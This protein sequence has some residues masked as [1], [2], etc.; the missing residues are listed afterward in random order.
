MAAALG[1]GAP[2]IPLTLRVVVE[3][4][5]T[6]PFVVRLRTSR[7]GSPPGTRDALLD[8]AADDNGLAFNTSDARLTVFGARADE[9]DNDVVLLVPRRGTLRRLIRA[10]AQ[11]NALLVTE[12]CD[13]LC[14]MCSQPPKAR[15]VD[16]FPFL[17][18]AARLAPRGAMLGVTGGEPLSSSMSYSHS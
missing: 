17:A 11:H 7:E 12:Q 4:G 1:A 2:V 10:S 9:L 8:V 14:L 13:Q 5:D 6:S 15:H 18:T 16:Y 3:R